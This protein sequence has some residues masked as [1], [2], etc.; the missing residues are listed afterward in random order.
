MILAVCGK[1]GVGKTTVTALTARA[2]LRSSNEKV[3]FIDA[4][5]AGGL[6]LALGINPKMTLED[7][8]KELSAEIK[9][10]SKDKVEIALSADYL[11]ARALEERENLAFLSIGRP[12][13]EGCYCRVNV[14]LKDAI[15]LLAGEFDHVIVD[16]EA[17]IE[18]VN[19]RVLSSV[20]SLLLVCDLSVKALRVAETIVRVGN[21]ISGEKMNKVVFN[22]V[23]DSRLIPDFS[24]V[25]SLDFAGWIP[26]D[27]EISRFDEKAISFFDL[28]DCNASVVVEKI[29]RDIGLFS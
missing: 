4:D 7:V 25:T 5:P 8:R 14:L 15:E 20:N 24:S 19:R 28:P 9:A 18:Q 13:D 10:G 21:R 12:E 27:E 3:L 2:F 16:A 6:G 23:T 11:I 29:V 17:G 1:G 22:R 26:E